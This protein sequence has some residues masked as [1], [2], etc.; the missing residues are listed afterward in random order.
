MCTCRVK[1]A[2]SA[3]E[4]ITKLESLDDYLD[5]L[6]PEW[7]KS[8]ILHSPLFH[9]HYAT[10]LVENAD[11][12]LALLKV[13][14]CYYSPSTHVVAIHCCSYGILETTT[15][16]GRSGKATSYKNCLRGGLE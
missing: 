16:E 4:A 14:T 10:R 7:L 1:E 3:L 13:C 11:S 6:T 5:S 9:G 15:G 2:C 8:L 12:C